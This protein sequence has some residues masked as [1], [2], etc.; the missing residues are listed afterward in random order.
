MFSMK[1]RALSPVLRVQ[2]GAVVEV[3]CSLRGFPL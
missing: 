2:F 1:L 3:F